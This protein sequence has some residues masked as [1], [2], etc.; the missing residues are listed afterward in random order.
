MHELSLCGSIYTIVDCA[1]GGRPVAVIHLRIGRLRQVI[2]DT[3]QYCWSLVCEQTRLEG[4]E[5]AV[6]SVPVTLRCKAC[7]GETASHDSL[8]LCGQCGSSDV[9]VLTGEEFLLTSLELAEV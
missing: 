9:A 2:P 3:L 6:D 4:S 1:A 5:L 7:Q 8:L